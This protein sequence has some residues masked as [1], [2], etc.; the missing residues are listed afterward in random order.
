MFALN[1]T[2]KVS[3]GSNAERWNPTVEPLVKVNYHAAYRGRDCT[4]SSGVVVHKY[5]H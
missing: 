2:T 3:V 4:S 1:V 5:H